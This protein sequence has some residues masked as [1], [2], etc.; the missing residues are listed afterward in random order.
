MCVSYCP[1]GT[2]CVDTLQPPQGTAS[3]RTKSDSSLAAHGSSDTRHPC[4]TSDGCWPRVESPLSR[5]A[6]SWGRS[7][8]RVS[9]PRSLLF[10]SL[11]LFFLLSF[12]LLPPPSSLLVFLLRCTK[13]RNFHSKRSRLQR[14]L[15][16]VDLRPVPA[17]LT[18]CACTTF[19]DPVWV[20]APSFC[21]KLVQGEHLEACTSVPQQ[22]V[23]PALP[24]QRGS[25]GNC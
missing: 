23:T 17:L 9:P 5:E 22:G 10:L 11:S 19:P 12:L 16:A 1:H 25:P 15:F 7:V 6:G 2:M 18:D 4:E 21:R 24:L 13:W 3:P 14:F 20:S 8:E